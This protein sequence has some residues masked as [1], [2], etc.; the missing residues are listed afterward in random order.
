MATFP[1]DVL[2]SSRRGQVVSMHR[3]GVNEFAD[4]CAFGR[5]GCARRHVVGS[6]AEQIDLKFVF[7]GVPE[8]ANL[9]VL[10]RLEVAAVLWTVIPIGA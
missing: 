7:L 5:R 2:S 3:C 9:S 4:H 8:N 6:A 1:D 10:L